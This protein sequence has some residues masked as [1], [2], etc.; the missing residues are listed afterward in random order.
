MARSENER[1][2]DEL[3]RMM[4][5]ATK[6]KHT[7]RK[8]AAE[9]V[10]P[11]EPEAEQQERHDADPERRQHKNV[12]EQERPE[13]HTG[14][15]KK[16]PEQHAAQAQRRERY[17]NRTEAGEQHT[18]LPRH[19]E[20]PVGGRKKKKRRKHSGVRVYGVLIMLT[21]IFVISISLSVGIIEVGKDMLGINGTE[22]LVVFNIPDGATTADIAED[23]KEAGLIRIPKAF[24]YFTRLSNED[25]NFIPGDHEISSSMAYEAII[26]ELTGTA[27]EEDKVYV[28]VMFPEG[29]TLNEAA[30]RLEEANVCESSRF[31]YFFNAGGLGYNFENYLPSNSSKLK[32]NKMEGYLFPDTYNFYEGMDPEDVCQRIYVNFD[33]KITQEY[34]DRMEELDITLDETITLAS[35]IQAEAANEDE[36]K[37]ISSVFWNRLNDSATFPKLQSDPTSKYVEIT[38]KPNIDLADEAIF[39]AYD[40]YVC[41]GLPAGAIGNPGLAAIEAALYPNDT[42]Y[43]Y[44]YA[45]TENSVTYFAETLE[46]HN[47]NIEMVKQ[48]HA[49]TYDPDAPLDEG[50]EEPENGEA[51]E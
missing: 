33:S 4:S 37:D 21:L 16:R 8:K 2:Y 6:P 22:T 3:L 9:P 44:F 30:Y 39:D 29:I 48:I 50:E 7:E 32:F 26:S 31:L 35:M 43:C 49:G 14:A 38:I 25:A 5:D 47:Q 11:E 28:D 40:T 36:M 15:R 51:D 24:I 18:E 42:N 41:N 13:R 1:S 10:H 19:H 27:E 17:V 45:D 34:Y 23:L 12:R 46:E 20:R